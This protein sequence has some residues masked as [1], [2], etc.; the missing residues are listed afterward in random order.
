MTRRRI[1]LNRDWRFRRGDRDYDERI[2]LPHT[3]DLPYFRT[4]EF[5]VGEGVYR[6]TFQVEEAWRSQRFFVAF[7][8]VFQD[9][10]VF[11][12]DT[13]IGRHLGGYTAFEFDV[14]DAI[15]TGDNELL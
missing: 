1:N 9:A 11:V 5:Y 2:G 15:R 6:R 3:F 4:P 12:N 14:T 10:E 8:G 13:R 7:E